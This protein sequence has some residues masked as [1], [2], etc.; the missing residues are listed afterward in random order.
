ML[1]KYPRTV[2]L[3]SFDGLTDN[4]KIFLPRKCSHKKFLQKLQ[5][6]SKKKKSKKGNA[7]RVKM[8]MNY[9]QSNTQ[10]DRQTH[11]QTDKHTGRQTHTLIIIMIQLLLW[12]QFS[13]LTV[14]MMRQ[15]FLPLDLELIWLRE[16]GEGGEKCL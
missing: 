9:G 10:A 14:M 8:F 4:R 6:D 7:W 5:L 11:K 13:E 2:M 3:L 12:F 1:T 15:S 16:S